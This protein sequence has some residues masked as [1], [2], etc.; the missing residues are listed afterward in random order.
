MADLRID[1]GLDVTHMPNRYRNFELVSRNHCKRIRIV[2]SPRGVSLDESVNS[3]T[4][5]SDQ[6]RMVREGRRE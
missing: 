3:W 2:L 4:P 6:R 5:I 1:I